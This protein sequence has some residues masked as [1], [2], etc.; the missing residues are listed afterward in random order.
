MRPRGLTSDGQGV[1]EVSKT[2]GLHVIPPRHS[3]SLARTAMVDAAPLTLWALLIDA[4]AGTDFPSEGEG[5][6]SGGRK[7]RL[8]NVK[9][10]PHWTAREVQ[11][12][13]LQAAGLGHAKGHHA[14][15]YVR[16][17]DSRGALLPL[18]PVTLRSSPTR[19]LHLEISSSNRGA[20]LPL[21]PKAF[22]ET[23][24]AIRHRLE[25]RVA[26]VEAGLLGLEGRRA[27]VLDEELR[28]IQDTLNYMSRRL[29]LTNAPAWVAGAQT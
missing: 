28:R 17:R 18:T 29:D 15:C 25:A 5:A 26:A 12:A 19:P 4:D 13:L 24:L 3:S 10:W 21:L 20:D 7:K 11:A 27:A 16:L 6:A 8:L 22:R 23:V 2:G 14:H 1:V 9:M